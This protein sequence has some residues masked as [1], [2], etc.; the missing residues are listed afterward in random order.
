[1]PFYDGTLDFR[2]F[3]CGDNY[4]FFLQFEKRSSLGAQFCFQRFNLVGL[5]W[6]DSFSDVGESR[7]WFASKNLTPFRM[8]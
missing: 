4:V 6:Y 8:H 3:F 7:V 2:P 1:M 5:G